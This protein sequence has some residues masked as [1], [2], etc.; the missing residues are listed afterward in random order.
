MR[1]VALKAVLRAGR[2]CDRAE[3]APAL[4]ALLARPEWLGVDAPSIAASL[5]GG[6]GGDVDVSAFGSRAAKPNPD[7][8]RWFVH[9]MSRWRDLP[10]GA[11]ASAAAIYRPDIHDIAV[12]MS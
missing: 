6:V 11:A 9:Q 1:V 12:G 4:A 2:A 8:A 5:P 3:D 7:H 10:D